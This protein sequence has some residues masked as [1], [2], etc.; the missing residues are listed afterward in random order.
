L[1]PLTLL[2]RRRQ[3]LYRLQQFRALKVPLLIIRMEQMI[4]WRIGR[5]IKTG[6]RPS[7]RDWQENYQKFVLIHNVDMQFPS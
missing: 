4:L 5:Q 2:F 6:Q 3:S 1:I 7:Y